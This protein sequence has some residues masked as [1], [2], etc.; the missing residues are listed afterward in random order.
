MINSGH[1][2]TN[3]GFH[4]SGQGW[5]HIDGWIDLPVVQ[6]SINED[7]TFGNITGKIRNWMGDIIV[8]HSQDGKLS[9]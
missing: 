2:L 3:G 5:E 7:L 9:D 6:V 8:W 1:S 4:E